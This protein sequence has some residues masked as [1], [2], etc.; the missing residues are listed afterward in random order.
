MN[1][2]EGMICKI[3]FWSE[4]LASFFQNTWIWLGVMLAG[5]G[6]C[7]YLPILIKNDQLRHRVNLMILVPVSLI[8]ILYGYPMGLEVFRRIA[9][10]WK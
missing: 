6:L 5:F 3:N 9:I 4:R 2:G 8:L 1:Q 7:A 10:H